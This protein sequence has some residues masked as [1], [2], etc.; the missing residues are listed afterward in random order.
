MKADS[1]YRRRL[2]IGLALGLTACLVAYAAGF[3]LKASIGGFWDRQIAELRALQAVDPVAAD[4]KRNSLAALVAGGLWALFAPILA[5]YAW[6]GW[7][8]LKAPQWP[9]PGT[10]LFQDTVVKRGGRLKTTAWVGLSIGILGYVFVTWNC[11]QLY[12]LMTDSRPEAH[13]ASARPAQR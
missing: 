6:L 11:Y 13:A 2:F 12:D 10:R 8:M 4:A 3:D 5:Y 1:V 9:L 7:R